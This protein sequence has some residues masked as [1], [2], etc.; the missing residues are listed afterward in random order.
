MVQN[1]PPSRRTQEGALS[2]V[3]VRAPHRRTF[4]AVPK[5]VRTNDNSP[6]R[7]MQRTRRAATCGRM[8]TKPV[9]SRQLLI[10]LLEGQVCHKQPRFLHAPL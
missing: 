3:N 10:E 7:R 8:V 4:S 6:E 5:K 2:T 9:S 1:R